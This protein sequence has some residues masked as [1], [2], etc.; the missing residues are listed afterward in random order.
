MPAL[1]GI[2]VLEMG[3]YAPVRLATKWHGLMGA[4]VIGIERPPKD[5]PG[6]YALLDD[7][8]HSH[9]TGYQLNKESMIL[10]LREPEGQEV[11]H[12]LV[13]EADVLVEGHRPGT[14]AKFGADYETL[15]ELNPRLI[16]CSVTGLGQT[17]PYADLFVHEPNFQALAGI[18]ARTGDPK[19]GPPVLSG[20][21]I[22]NRL[23]GSS[24]ATIG[25][26]AA[27]WE[28][29]TTGLGQHV[30][31]SCVMGTIGAAGRRFADE[32]WTSGRLAPRGLWSNQDGHP[33]YGVYPTKDGKF[34]TVCDREPWAWRKLCEAI[35]RPE[36]KEHALGDDG[37]PNVALRSTMEEAFSERT[38]D[39][40]WELDKEQNLGITPV[41][42]PEEVVEDEHFNEWG[43]FGEVEYGRFG[44]IRQ[45]SLPFK[46]SDS[47][48]VLSFMPKFGEHTAEVLAKLGYDEATIER[49]EKAGIAG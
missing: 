26:L 47:P 45:V 46:L 42:E 22:G 16:Y 13:A 18:L 2:T 43:I 14:L 33:G 38:R 29:Q 25:I 17:G 21:A 24:M 8:E 12:R 11:L 5:R 23:G 48:P 27:L 28:R 9:W 41:L 3:A 6:A 36:L 4:R 20:L 19:G 37:K 49:F 34:I 35:G 40:W 31:A 1:E 44:R 39:E 30:D 10:N 15:H 7:D 32:L